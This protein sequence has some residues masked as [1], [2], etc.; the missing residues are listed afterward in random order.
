MKIEF[1]YP[2][3]YDLIFHVLAYL[4]VNNASDLYDEKYIE[5]MAHDLTPKI[6]SLQKYYNENFE[7]LALVNFLPYYCG[8][9]FDEMK[10]SFINCGRFTQEDLSCF[11]Y[12]F[13]EILDCESEFFFDYWDKRHEK[14]AAMRS[15]TE[16]KFT[17]E[18][19][20]FSRLFNYFDRSCKILF[21]YCITRHGRGFYDDIHF[22]ALVR[23]PENGEEF[24]SSLFQLLHEYTH[25]FTDKLLNANINMKDGSHDLSEN[26]VIWADYYLLKSIDRGLFSMYFD[27]L[28]NV[29]NNLTE[30]SFPNIFRIDKDLEKE[31]EKLVDNIL[32]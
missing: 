16:E 10:N 27:W 4:K 6:N 25:N 20:K 14:L 23:F 3:H 13:I 8:G 1:I 22:S 32:S 5:R 29:A 18:L 24:I 21:S 30:A 9:G 28:K 7:R 31:I 11:I 12:P 19:E 26:I 2:K 17:R 15:S